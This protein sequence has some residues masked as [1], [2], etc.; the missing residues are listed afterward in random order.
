MIRRFESATRYAYARICDD[1]PILDIEKDVMQKF[2]L[3]SRWAKDAVSRAKATYAGAEKLV[4]KGK[5]ESPRKLIWG[6]HKNF[7]RC[8]KGELSNEEWRCIRS[9]QF[10]SRGDKSKGGN[11]NLRIEPGVEDYWLRITIGNRQWIRCRLWIPEKFRMM[12]NAHLN[13]EPC[14][15]VRVKRG[16]DNRYRVYITFDVEIP[17][18]SVGLEAG[19]IGVDLNPSGQAWA[20]TNAQGQLLSKGWTNTPELQHARRGRRDWLIGQVAHQIVDLVKSTGKGLVVERLEFKRDKNRGRKLNR[21]F[22]N[23]VHSRLIEAILREAQQQGVV[24]KQVNPT[25]SSVIGRM[26]YQ[27]VYPHLAVHEA[28]AYVLA[29]RGL[30]FIDMPTGSQRELAM[31]ATEARRGKGKLHYWAF[32]QSLKRA[33]N[34]GNGKS[35]GTT[36]EPEQGIAPTRSVGE[37][38]TPYRGKGTSGKSKKGGVGSSMPLV[39]PGSPASHLGCAQTLRHSLR[40]QANRICRRDHQVLCW[41]SIQNSIESSSSR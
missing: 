19:A 6:G 21:I 41:S 14:Y 20:E 7:E 29:R 11:L 16:T 38:P 12:L 33:A 4:E 10:W 30:G 37:S 22:N 27:R 40:N 9:S 34:S 3:N 18:Q 2:N 32:W 25:F 35:P 17:I 15:T 5:L 36:G 28:A 1:V 39:Q 24:V 13:S 8:S 31:K 26:K 23:F